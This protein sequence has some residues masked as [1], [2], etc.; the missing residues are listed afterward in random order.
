V[1]LRILTVCVLALTTAAC[2][3]SGDNPAGPSGNTGT[4]NSGSGTTNQSLAVTIDGVAFNP[5]TVTA[6]RSA[7]NGTTPALVLVAG[8]NGTTTFAFG[9]VAQVGV[10]TIGV[11]TGVNANMTIVNGSAGTG[12]LAFN[13]LG[14]GSIT[15]TSLTATAVAGRVDLVLAPTV[16]GANKAVSGTYNV[17]F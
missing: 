17:A 14:S 16:G 10:Q 4:G 8:T 9:A 5:S 2:G 12:Y 3:G 6:T 7:A 13:T 1:L 15:V 11:T